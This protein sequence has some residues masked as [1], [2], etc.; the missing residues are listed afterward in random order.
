MNEGPFDNYNPLQVVCLHIGIG[1]GKFNCKE[2]V[3][4]AIR[5]ATMSPIHG[6]MI[7]SSNKA[8]LLIDIDGLTYF[9]ANYSQAPFFIG[10]IPTQYSELQSSQRTSCLILVGIKK[11]HCIHFVLNICQI[12]S[13]FE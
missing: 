7:R 11:N 9:L 1:K 10:E 8:Q 2:R 5:M 6:F 3:K 4:K 13:R 12:P